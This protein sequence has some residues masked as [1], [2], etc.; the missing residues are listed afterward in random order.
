MD[1]S[2]NLIM[3]SEMGGSDIFFFVENFCDVYYVSKE[4]IFIWFS[5]DQSWEKKK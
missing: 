3:S 1:K 4:L 5:L 2:K